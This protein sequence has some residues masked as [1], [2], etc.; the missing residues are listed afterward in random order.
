MSLKLKTPVL[1]NQSGLHRF[2]NGDVYEGEFLDGRMHGYGRYRWSNGSKYEGEYQRGERHGRGKMTWPDGCAYE[3]EFRN[4][5]RSGVGVFLFTDGM[6]YEGDFW[7][8]RRHGLGTMRTQKCWR[9]PC[10]HRHAVCR[11]LVPSCLHT[12]GANQSSTRNSGT[13]ANSRSLWVTSVRPRERACAAMKRSWL[14]MG[15]PARS[16]VARISA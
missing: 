13:R 14:P 6:R 8:G 9:S 12:D 7:K 1:R 15:V 2:P 10:V 16:S 3:G 5:E 4:G 11:D